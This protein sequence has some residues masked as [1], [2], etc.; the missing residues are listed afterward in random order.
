MP[1]I[2]VSIPKNG[3]GAG[4]ATSKVAEI[5]IIDVDDIKTEPTRTVGDPKMVGDYELNQEAKAVAIYATPSTID[6]TE[7]YSGEADARGV[8]QGVAFEHPGDDVVIKGFTEAYMNRGVVAMVK[9]CD[10][11]S[12]RTIVCGSKCNPLFMSVESTN[13]KDA[14]K[15]KFT[16]KQ[17]LNDKFLPGDYSGA[18][19]TVADPAKNEQEGA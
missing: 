8:K 4:C 14:T 1:Y 10:G 6:I 11:A 12:H 9:V 2:Q 18:E 3:N 16:F 13:N 17:E 5:I 7:E 15:R 19:I